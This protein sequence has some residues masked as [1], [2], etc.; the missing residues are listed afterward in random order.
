MGKTRVAQQDAS[1][2]P[3]SRRGCGEGGGGGEAGE[4]ASRRSLVASPPPTSPRA[5]PSLPAVP[6]K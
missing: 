6:R 4:G 1:R 3:G 5:T 2:L